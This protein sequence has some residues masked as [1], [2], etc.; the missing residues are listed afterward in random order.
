MN[1]CKEPAEN[2]EWLKEWS[3]VCNITAKLHYLQI[4]WS[5]DP[6]SYAVLAIT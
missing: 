4:K 6:G 1:V 2:G 3:C 5:Y